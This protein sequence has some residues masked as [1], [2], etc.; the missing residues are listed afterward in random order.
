MIEANV[1]ALKHRGR[2]SKTPAGCLRYGAFG[3]VACVRILAS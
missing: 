1:R 2:R 3:A